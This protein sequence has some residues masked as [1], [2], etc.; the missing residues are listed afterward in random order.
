MVHVPS[1]LQEFVVEQS[2][3]KYTPIDQAVWRYV[4]RQNRAF[5]ENKAHPAYVD[6]LKSTGIGIESIPRIEWMNECL[7]KHGWG[8]VSID[9]FL[10]SA[11]FMDFQAHGILPIAA[12][13]RTNE[14]IAYTPAPDILHEAAG[15][16]PII[17]NQE[18]AAYLRKI[19]SVGAKA[20]STKEDYVLYEA[21]RLL[22]MLK[23]DPEASAEQIRQ[24]EEGL[25]QAQDA[26]TEVSEIQMVSRLYWWTVEYGLTGDVDQPRIYGAGLLSSVG[27]S[28]R[29]LQP[30][31]AKLP[32]SLDACIQT[33]YDITDY[34]PQLF[35]CR[36]FGELIQAVEEL[37]SR[38]ACSVGATKSLEMALQSENFTT[39]VYS[40]GLQVTGVLA[41]IEYDA[42]GEA[43]YLQY[44]GPT[45][46]AYRNVEL[47]GHG[48]DD[49]KEGYG[50]PVG[51]LAGEPCAI[52]DFSET[53]VQKW[54]L[55]EGKKVALPFESGVKVTGTVSYVQR[56][57]GKIMLIG[58]FD[59]TV[60]YQGQV[61]FQPDW[62]I[63]DMA[64]GQKIISVFAGAADKEKF[65][66]HT[67]KKS[68]L[69]TKRR[70]ISP[71]E[72]QLHALYGQIRNLRSQ[73]A[74]PDK[75]KAQILYVSKQLKS[76][77][78]NDW[79]LR[80]EILELLTHKDWLADERQE[81]LACLQQLQAI[82][83]N[84]ELIQNGLALIVNK[85]RNANR[86]VSE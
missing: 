24:A 44:R 83:E 22:S 4:M 61:L 53:E 42:Q 20:L 86:E 58:L 60:S 57:A 13:I 32:F 73:Q 7:S 71:R 8:A 3:D 17:K 63:Y 31:V 80:L 67:E 78:P 65:P 69:S 62:G 52:E 79:L 29:C 70:Q 30:D 76:E 14:H 37:E 12:D 47:A 36:S 45:A 27:E 59:C 19:G 16:A 77:F 39:A 10:S 35:V 25:V 41:G 50:S 82:P 40:S 15:H 74:E 21:I 48:K 85:G 1:H 5:L 28:K 49:H 56:Q 33:G 43:A 72:A 64:V 46:L 2:Y 9:G 38:L 26:L 51:R 55:I 18:Y 84:K 34:Q 11:A 81:L 23:E 75:A 68:S 6:G 54:N 66:A